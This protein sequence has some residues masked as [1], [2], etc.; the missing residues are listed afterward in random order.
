MLI[1]KKQSPIRFTNIAFIASFICLYSIIPMIKL[2]NNYY[3]PTLPNQINN[4]IK[5]DDATQ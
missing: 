3:N 5:F 2:I 1:L 4:M